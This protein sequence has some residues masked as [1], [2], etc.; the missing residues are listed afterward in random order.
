MNRWCFL[1]LVKWETRILF[2]CKI[3][4]THRKVQRLMTPVYPSP[5][6]DSVTL[7]P[8]E[9][10]PPSTQTRIPKHQAFSVYLLLSSYQVV[11]DSLSLSL[12]ILFLNFIHVHTYRATELVWKFSI[13]NSSNPV[14]GIK[15]DP[16]KWGEPPQSGLTYLHSAESVSLAFWHGSGIIDLCPGLVCPLE[17]Q[18]FF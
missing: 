11:S 2:I 8:S 7:H 9:C 5:R 12:C 15:L 13:A 16:T 10:L 3:R 17:N 6:L 18:T 4:Q 1:R 14:K